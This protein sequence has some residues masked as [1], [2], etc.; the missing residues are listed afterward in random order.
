MLRRAR[1]LSSTFD[2]YCELHMQ[3]QFKL[4]AEQ[5]RQVDYLLY[6]TQPFYKFTTRLSKTKDVTVHNVFRVYN[7]LFDHLE[8]SI[9]QLQ[10][11][12]VPWK[13]A[14]LHALHAG[15]DKLKIYYTKTQEI[16]GNLYAVGTILAPQYKL[17]F[18]S[19]GEYGDDGES[20]ARY[21]EYLRQYLEPYQRRLSESQR[22]PIPSSPPNDNDFDDLFDEDMPR[23]SQQEKVNSNNELT[24]YLE[25]GKYLAPF[26]IKYS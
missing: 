14:M 25:T 1:R 6:L 19:G 24:D 7:Q 18:F 11:K 10:R 20:R 13:Q 16:H 12:K 26:P 17:K 21:K 5:W 23:N 3:G 4:N 2:M 8:A 15:R 22:P 9:R